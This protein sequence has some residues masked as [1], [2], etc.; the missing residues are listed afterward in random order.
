MLLD[1]KKIKIV[2]AVPEENVDEVRNAM[3]SAG[4]G[5][6]GEYSFCSMAT[7]ILGTFI[8]SENSNPYCG[9][10]N[11]L[12]KYEEIK[13][14]SVCTVDNIKNVVSAIKSVHPYEE[15]GIDIYPLIDEEQF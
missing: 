6:I 12:Q 3:C 7:K 11:G 9:D 14:E 4:A 10:K 2:V 5:V 13:L 15:P 1:V 8:A